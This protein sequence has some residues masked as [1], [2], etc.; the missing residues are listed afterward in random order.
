[1]SDLSCIASINFNFEK[2]MLLQG[3][4][5]FLASG[6]K[7]KDNRSFGIAYNLL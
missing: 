5:Y 1:M 6:I 2:Y 4:Y 7:K 3:C